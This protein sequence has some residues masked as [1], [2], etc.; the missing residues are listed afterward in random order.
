[1][2]LPSPD[3]LIMLPRLSR[4]EADPVRIGN[5]AARSGS[6]SR[7]EWLFGAG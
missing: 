2:N 6:E 5:H 7:V 1:M 3:C 4:V